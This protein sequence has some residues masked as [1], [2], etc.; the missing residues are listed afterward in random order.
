MLSN[1]LARSVIESKIIACVASCHPGKKA[2]CMDL[3]NAAGVI[4]ESKT[5]SLVYNIYSTSAESE[6]ITEL[7]DYAWS[8]SD[9]LSKLQPRE[10]VLLANT[11]RAGSS[12]EAI[13][14]A[15]ISR[16]I[17]KGLRHPKNQQEPI[18]KLEVLD[19]S[20]QSEDEAVLR[21]TDVLISRY[22]MTVFP[23][24]SPSSKTLK[25]CSELG[26]PMVRILAG[27]IGSLQGL[28][29]KPKLRKL[30]EESEIPLFF[31]GGL[32]TADHVKEAIDLGATGVLM[33]AA[34]QRSD[35]P[36]ELAKS[37]RSVIDSH[38]G[39]V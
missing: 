5:R 10:Y 37:V 16:S 29:D 28:I 23:L 15:L 12:K 24:I 1:D 33:N 6:S 38:T 27:K 30:A 32:G 8:F 39:H 20:L 3:Q 25:R 14:K 36:I 35:S 18:I 2:C 7:S 31:E 22:D 4:T 17:F 34:F 11:S 19:R 21:A 13:E 9:L 26:V